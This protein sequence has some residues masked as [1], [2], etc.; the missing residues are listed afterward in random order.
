MRVVRLECPACGTEVSGDFDLCPA[1][2]LDAAHR[3]IFDAFLRA[4]GNVRAVQGELGVSYP[5]A[6]QRIEEMFAALEEA[7][8]GPDPMVVLERLEAGQIDV[9]SAAEMLSGEGRRT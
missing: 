2:R 8:P 6:R 5:T 9:D 3:S 4:R 7:P 1:C